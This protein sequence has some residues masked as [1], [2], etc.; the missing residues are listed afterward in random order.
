[1]FLQESRHIPASHEA[2]SDLMPVFFDMLE[3]EE[4]PAV[5]VV[6]GHFVFVYIHP[7]LDGNGRIGRFLVNVMLA[8]GGYPWTV[9]PLDSREDYMS[10]LEAASVDQDIIPFAQFLAKLVK[11]ELEGETVA[12]LPEANAKDDL[13]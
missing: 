2:V 3:N 8:S 12:K 7:Y 4:N 13:S 1:M 6:L 9:G 10:S 11:H 5:R